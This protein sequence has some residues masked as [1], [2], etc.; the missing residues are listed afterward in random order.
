MA[1]SDTNPKGAPVKGGDIINQHKRMAM[2]L[3]IE[4]VSKAPGYRG[5]AGDACE[6]YPEAACRA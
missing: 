4:P 6:R 2:G 5:R 3:P 1:K